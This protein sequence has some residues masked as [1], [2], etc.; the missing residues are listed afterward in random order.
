MR[1]AAT[2]A[3]RRL[4]SSRSRT[5]A[6]ASALRRPL[7]AQAAAQPN[8]P[9][10]DHESIEL[11]DRSWSGVG[12]LGERPEGDGALEEMAKVIGKARF[13]NPKLEMMKKG[14]EQ[15]LQIKN[16]GKKNAELLAKA[17]CRSPE[18]LVEKLEEVGVLDCDEK[19][20]ASCISSVIHSAIR[21]PANGGNTDSPWY[22]ACLTH[23]LTHGQ[24]QS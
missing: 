20:V 1:T 2:R 5:P 12:M 24:L 6:P 9:A 22:G 7:A 4:A 11:F 8:P 18:A 17:G 3:A 15:L 16:V 13:Q 14:M 23:S 21:H 10:V 19:A